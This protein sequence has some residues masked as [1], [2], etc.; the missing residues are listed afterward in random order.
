MIIR[1]THTGKE[2]S[3]PRER[4]LVPWDSEYE[5]IPEDGRERELLNDFG[6]QNTERKSDATKEDLMNSV[7][8]VHERPRA[9]PPPKRFISMEDT[10]EAWL[11]KVGIETHEED[12]QVSF[13]FT[14]VAPA[15]VLKMR[16]DGN[17]LAEPCPENELLNIAGEFYANSVPEEAAEKRRQD[18]GRDF[19]HVSIGDMMQVYSIMRQIVDDQ[20]R[21]ATL[22]DRYR[23]DRLAAQMA[24]TPA[25]RVHVG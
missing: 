8:L 14:D 12:G 23:L 15:D 22:L 21:E 5:L 1:E 17:G 9:E 24:D 6:I 11:K 18:F 13:S 4:H 3:F 25:E 7:E 19:G 20:L 10:I 2:F 16:I